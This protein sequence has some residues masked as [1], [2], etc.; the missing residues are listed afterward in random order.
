MCGSRNFWF[1]SVFF[2]VRFETE[3]KF[4]SEPKSRC[5]FSASV[6]LAASM[7]N[8]KTVCVSSGKNQ[9][10]K[11]IS[12]KLYMLQNHIYVGDKI[13]LQKNESHLYEQKLRTQPVFFGS[14]PEPNRTEVFQSFGSVFGSNAKPN[15]TDIFEAS[16]ISNK[17]ATYVWIG[18]ANIRELTHPESIRD[19]NKGCQTLSW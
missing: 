14:S 1:G 19:T 15:R 11:T 2:M 3:P 10:K 18:D 16:H 12:L 9:P 6:L 5:G 4:R 8:K 7:S 17:D 13:D